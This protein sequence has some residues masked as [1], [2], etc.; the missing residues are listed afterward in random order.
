MSIIITRFIVSAAL[1]ANKINR[2]FR[3]WNSSENSITIPPCSAIAIVKAFGRE[4]LNEDYRGA[5]N[6]K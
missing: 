3:A 5:E 2:L 6:F 1:G 4:P